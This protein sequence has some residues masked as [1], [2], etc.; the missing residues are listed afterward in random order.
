M[1]V[2]RVIIVNSKL[3]Y[4][5]LTQEGFLTQS[6]MDQILIF[7]GNFKEEKYFFQWILKNILNVFKN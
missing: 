4:D 7:C 3:K 1:T 5:H 6:I 2:L